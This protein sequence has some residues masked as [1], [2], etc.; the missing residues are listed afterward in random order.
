MPYLN[1]VLEQD[2]R[3]I[4]RRVNASQHFRSFCAARRT[5]AGYEAIRMIRKRPGFWKCVGTGHRFAPS[6]YSRSVRCDELNFRSSTPTFGS[7]AK[8][9]HIL[10]NHCS[11]EGDNGIVG[12][13]APR[14]RHPVEVGRRI[15]ILDAFH[16]FHSASPDSQGM[17]HVPLVIKLSLQA[18]QFS[19]TRPP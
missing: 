5:L 18:S 8:L 2:H 16:L 10:P 11:P 17:Y 13:D 1:N 15:R 4:K 3:A 7:T 14:H 12:D 9:Q 19:S 6:L